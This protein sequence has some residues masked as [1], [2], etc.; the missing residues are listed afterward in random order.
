MRP[1]EGILYANGNL[2]SIFSTSYQINFTKLSFIEHS[3]G[4]ASFIQNVRVFFMEHGTVDQKINGNFKASQEYI[5]KV[6]LSF[7][8]FIVTTKQVMEKCD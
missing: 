2:V 7:I 1:D 5:I 4:W 8:V 3:S 6:T